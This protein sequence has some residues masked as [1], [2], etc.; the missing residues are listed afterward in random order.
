VRPVFE[1][2]NYEGEQSVTFADIGALVVFAG[3][4]RFQAKV[5]ATTASRVNEA[6]KDD[7]DVIR[8]QGRK[9][10]VPSFD[11]LGFPPTDEDV[12]KRL[13]ARVS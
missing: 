1:A 11:R 5:M 9:I 7:L 8:E 12:I 10:N 2:I 4:V 13:T 6:A 3:D